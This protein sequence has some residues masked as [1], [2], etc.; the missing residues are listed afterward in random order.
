MRVL[1]IAIGIFGIGLRIV[2]FLLVL[3]IIIGSLQ[4]VH[5]YLGTAVTVICCLLGFAPGIPVA[6]VVLLIHHDWPNLLFLLA[7]FIAAIAVNVIATWALV[8]AEK[9]KA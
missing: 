9:K 8:F 1:R 2:G 4:N 6:F 3:S 5:F 7:E